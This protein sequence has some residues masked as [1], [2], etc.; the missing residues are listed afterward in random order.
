M[1]HLTT[2][3]WAEFKYDGLLFEDLVHDL[4]KLEYPGIA[5]YATKKSWDGSRDFEATINLL[6]EAKAKIWLEC[7]YHQNDRLPVHDVSMTLLMAFIHNAK[8]IIIFS[9]SPTNR[10]FEKHIAD[11]T[12]RTKTDVEIY[13]DLR[14]EQLILTHSSSLKN[15]NKYFPTFK[16]E[17]DISQHHSDIQYEFGIGTK[18]TDRKK[19]IIGINQ[20]FELELYIFNHHSK[21]R[22]IEISIIDNVKDYFH[23]ASRDLLVPEYK[24]LKNIPPNSSS[25]I[26]LKMR[27]KSYSEKIKLPRISIKEE[28]GR[29]TI[30]KIDQ[31]LECRWIATTPLIGDSYYEILNNCGQYIGN[32]HNFSVITIIGTSGVGKSRILKELN[33]YS[34]DINNIVCYID[35]DEKDITAKLFVEKLVLTLEDL[36][37]FDNK[38]TKL[39]FSSNIEDDKYYACKIL[40]DKSFSV[41]NEKENVVKYLSDLLCR[42][43]CSIILDNLQAYD[44]L[45]VEIID[46]LLKYMDERDSVSSLIL[47]FNLD[48][49]YSDTDT[50][51]LYKRLLYLSSKEEYGYYNAQIEGFTRK[52]AIQ[53]LQESLIKVYDEHRAVDTIT[54]QRSIEKIVDT[55]GTNPFFLHEFILYLLQQGV[56]RHTDTTSYYIHDI[57]GFQ[58]CL[59]TTPTSI[60]DLIAKREHLFLESIK[61]F[62]ALTKSYENLISVIALTKSLPLILFNDLI[63]DNNLLRQLERIGFINIGMDDHIQFSHQFFEKYFISRYSL[64]SK[65]EEFRQKLLK[66]FEQYGYTYEFFFSLFLVKK[67][68]NQLSQNDFDAALE[69]I[70]QRDVEFN[71][72]LEIFNIISDYLDSSI[73]SISPKT[74]VKV[75][76]QIE[77]MTVKRH[78]MKKCLI[79]NEKVFNQFICN[80]PKF[81][82]HLTNV[83]KLLEEYVCHLLNLQ[84]FN[85]SLKK[86]KQLTD[87]LENEMINNIGCKEVLINMYIRQTMVYYHLQLVENAEFTNDKAMTL[88]QSIDDRE[89]IIECWK[90]K[91]DIYYHNYDADLYADEIIDAWSMAYKKYCEYSDHNIRLSLKLAIALKAIRVDILKNDLTAAEPKIEFISSCIDK[92]NMVFYEIIIR[93]VKAMFLIIKYDKYLS[94]EN[95]V[96]NEVVK[97]INQATDLCA[98]Y[99]NNNIY[100]NC[101]YLRAIAQF[102]ASKW[103]FSFDNFI[104]TL[105]IIVDKTEWNILEKKWSGFITDLM[106]YERKLNKKI[107]ESIES[108]LFVNEQIKESIVKIRTLTNEKFEDFFDNY[109]TKSLFKDKEKKIGFPNI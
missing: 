72:S 77:S 25:V 42:K 12:E 61:D 89:G 5:F 81:A 54:Y 60:N 58:I 35:A 65:P 103:D 17:V 47:S 40:Y 62:P 59:N 99:G 2:D 88:A 29:K 51:N 109:V 27:V 105:S 28:D 86:N 80:C 91:G 55:C 100:I 10:T 63:G 19:F 9:Y 13:D 82:E 7:K 98:I 108:K 44:E 70:M 90:S 69:K 56:I 24:I 4:L 74:Y 96:Y 37:L 20:P 71:Y 102:K 34:Q 1:I 106:I 46:L 18:K 85:E 53:Y 101:F 76:W 107:P 41:A 64:L 66:S 14:L 94:H 3:Y 87:L 97:L 95:S 8:Q 36:P 33:L 43:S 38:Q 26:R 104:K 39:C 32:A 52:E 79:Y 45:S 57:D 49:L 21:E 48:Y 93:L 50:H 68:L 83:F 73:E 75:Y 78:G 6:E 67:S 22:N 16:K 23:I 11:Y 92:T 15:F 84:E 30:C 31:K